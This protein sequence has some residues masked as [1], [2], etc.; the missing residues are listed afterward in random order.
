MRRIVWNEARG[1]HLL[2]QLNGMIKTA[3]PEA[4]FMREWA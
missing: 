1:K 3:S 4:K 2:E